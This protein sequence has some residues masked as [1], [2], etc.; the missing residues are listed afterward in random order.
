MKKNETMYVLTNG[1]QL[2][3][4][5]QDCVCAFTEEEAK[6][7]IKALEIENYSMQKAD[8]LCTLCR[9]YIGF[10]RLNE[11]FIDID[12]NKTTDGLRFK[13]ETPM[14]EVF[15]GI[16]ETFLDKGNP[17]LK[18]IIKNYLNK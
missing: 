7:Y 3:A 15:E 9:D 10:R 14:S 8:A 6:E 18:K 11:K 16:L 5:Y 13:Y 2:I 12:I 4:N 1:T 17:Y